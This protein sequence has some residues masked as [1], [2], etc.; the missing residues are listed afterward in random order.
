M[1]I[2]SVVSDDEK[3]VTIKVA[4]R[5]DF[6][7]H[8]DFVQVYKSY[9]KGEKSF[10]VDLEGAEYMDSSAMG[11]LLQLREYNVHGESVV[12][13]NGNDAVKDVLRIANFG[14]LFSIQ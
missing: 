2:S 3:T 13:M 7:T 14:K 6:S 1:S 11:M 12:L 5:F 9:S 8:Q 10:V 4:G